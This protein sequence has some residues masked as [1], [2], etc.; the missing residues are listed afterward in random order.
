[1]QLLHASY[2]QHIKGAEEMARIGLMDR[3]E[4]M[5]EESNR[6]SSR[7]H[8]LKEKEKNGQEDNNGND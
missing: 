4:E 8:E 3:A 6:L 7:I 1:M 5:R 2:Y